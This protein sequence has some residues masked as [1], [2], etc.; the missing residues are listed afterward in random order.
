VVEFLDPACPHSAKAWAQAKNLAEEYRGEVRFVI[1]LNPAGRVP[2]AELAARAALAAAKAGRAGRFLDEYFANPNVTAAWAL[3][4]G[5]A[6]GE[7]G[8]ASPCPDPLSIQQQAQADLDSVRVEAQLVSAIGTPILYVN[9]LRRAGFVEDD[10]LKPLLAEEIRSA[11]ALI[12]KGM[13]PE[14]VYPFLTARGVVTP[15]VEDST[16][17]IPIYD[18]LRFGPREAPAQVIVYWS[19][20]SPFCRNLWPHIR[21]VLDRGKENAA[22]TLRPVA[23]REDPLSYLMSTALICGTLKGKMESTHASLLAMTE[24]SEAKVLDMAVELGLDREEFRLCL[25]GEEATIYVDNY[26]REQEQEGLGGTPVVLVNG[27]RLKP[28]TGLDAYSILAGIRQVGIDLLS[29]R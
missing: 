22:V 3:A 21:L 26:V 16:H 18:P 1:K 10:Q 19:Y 29:L 4:C 6:G 12:D 7:E 9:G 27:R 23:D 5:P 2:E 20:R 13:R 17:N 14:A 11:A 15:L 24:A 8:I 25:G 28:P